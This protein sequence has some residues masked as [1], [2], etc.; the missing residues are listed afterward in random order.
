MIYWVL[1]YVVIGAV[2]AESVRRST[3]DTVY[4]FWRTDF[5]PNSLVLLVWP[6][7]VVGGIVLALTER[8]SLAKKAQAA[9]EEFKARRGR[10]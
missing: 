7:P 10:K 3:E 6:M 4:D 9:M 2:F 5:W 1:L 8:T